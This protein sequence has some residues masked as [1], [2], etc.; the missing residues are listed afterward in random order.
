MKK[1]NTEMYAML[2]N[3]NV[4]KSHS[5]SKLGLEHIHSRCL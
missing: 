2:K 1:E 5:V 4:A 3:K